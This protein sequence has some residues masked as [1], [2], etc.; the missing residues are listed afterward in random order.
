LAFFTG[1]QVESNEDEKATYTVTF[2]ANGGDGILPADITAIV[3][4]EFTLP[5]AELTK[6]GY[7][8]KG[9]NTASSGSGTTYEAGAKAK[10][11]STENG[12]TVTLYAK[13]LKE[14]D[15]SII[16]KNTE[17]AAN[18]NPA[19][20]N[21]E[22]ETITLK[23]AVKTG[24]IFDGWY[25]EDSFATKATEI[26]KGST[27][28]V[29]LYAKWTAITYT[30]TYELNGGTNAD[31]NPE[32]Y[33]VEIETIILESAT[34]YGYAL[35]GWYKEDSFATKVTE[36][37]KGSTGN[38][39]L[40][41]KWIITSDTVT[42]AIGALSGEG[43]HDIAVVG[44]ITS[45][46]ISAIA[47]ALKSN[48]EAK[49]NLDL[50][51]ATGL[52]IITGRAFENCTSLISVS[53]PGSVT[54]IKSN[55]FANCVNL[56]TV[57]IPDGVSS[58]W[59]SVFEGCTSLTSVNIP[60]SVTDVS[61]GNFKDCTS[62]KFN[63]FDNAKY[64]GNE[65]NP[66]F[67]LIE[68]KDTSITS[69]NINPATK[70][71]AGE[72]FKDCTSLTSVVIPDGVTSISCFTFEGCTSLTTVNIPDSVT[73]TLYTR[74]V[75]NG[76]TSLTTVNIPN[77]ATYIA[78][79]MFQNCSS[80]T[81]VTIPDSVTSIGYC[82]FE[83]CSKLASM[84]IPDGVTSID[85]F[86]F[87]KCSSLTSVSIP[88]SIT[89]IG[90]SAFNYCS[91]LKFNEFE[92]ANYLGNENNP[93]LVFIGVNDDYITS[94]NINETT[95]I[96]SDFAF[97]GCDNLTSVTIPVSVISIGQDVFNYL[98]DLKTVNYRGTKEQWNA[99]S[100]GNYNDSLANATINYNYTD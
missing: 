95:K 75:F 68:A 48:G 35:E 4:E 17:N 83:G 67:V 56:T 70:V 78:D 37:A 92:N 69:C 2:D 34:K 62:L 12:A 25:K 9:W 11:L 32:S 46:T 87:E 53:I 52:A 93:Y 88:D 8:F 97:S 22:T 45:E 27:G 98:D 90:G 6:I 21:V 7:N 15:Y 81:S 66:Y 86:A 58:I 31:G 61:F 19:S 41:A 29:T 74:S 82:A 64:L 23:E 49:V 73:F 77:G 30:I 91:N 76:C 5:A 1:C 55:A 85:S 84:T 59:Y 54:T 28:N 47:A 99:I 24:Y 14:G 89:S 13:W 79:N 71:I 96:I 20:Y 18:D 44:P 43:P 38:I 33:N 40:Y 10:D 65:S 50:S 3:G 63:E 57:S 100:I 26:A 36:I 16:Y 42:S 94:C 39:T 72:A 60:D 51:R 80:L